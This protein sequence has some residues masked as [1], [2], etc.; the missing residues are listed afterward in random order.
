MALSLM[1]ITKTIAIQVPGIGEKIKYARLRSPFSLAEICRQ[2]NM[3]TQ[4]WY[5]IEREEQSVPIKTLRKMEKILEIDLGINFD[6]ALAQE[7]D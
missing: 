3:S 2:I 5:R 6:N 7:E 4:N 1:K